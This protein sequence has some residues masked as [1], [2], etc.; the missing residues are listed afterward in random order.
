VDPSVSSSR[1]QT[2]LTG[3][4]KIPWYNRISND[5]RLLIIHT[6]DV[7]G[8]TITN[9][10]LFFCVSRTTVGSIMCVYYQQ[11]RTRKLPLG[12]NRK[13]ILSTEQ[14]VAV[15]EW[16]DS[17]CTLSLQALK[18][19]CQER[20]GVAVSKATISRVLLSFHYTIK[21][22]C[23]QPEWINMPQTIKARREYSNMFIGI[24]SRRKCM[25]FVDEC[26]FNCLMRHHS[27]RALRGMPAVICVPNI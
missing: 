5:Q 6:V 14:K 10:T 16:I 11:G 8:K 9:T 23:L 27:G 1:Q 19:A 4:R 3:T 12:G 24:M 21:C 25:Y 20:I 26:G 13:Q 2:S 7:L 22:I 17:D 15:L 18:L